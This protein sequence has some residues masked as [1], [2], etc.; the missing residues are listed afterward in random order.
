MKVRPA[1]ELPR[2]KQ[3]LRRRAIKLEWITLVIVVINIIV[4][5]FVL[6]NSQAMRTA[7]IEDILA[8]VPPL[9]FLTATHFETKSP[10]EKKP[11]GYFRAIDIAYLCASLALLVFGGYLLFESARTLI[12]GSHPSIGTIVIFGEQLWLGWLMIAGLVF[13]AIPPV[14]VGLL[15]LPVARQLH[16]K[17][18]YADA[19]MN[20]ADWLTSIAGIVG[21]GGIGLGFW[22]LDAAA[23]MIIAA[24]IAWDGIRN[25]KRVVEDLLDALPRQVESNREEDL[26]GKI[27]QT[28]Q[29][30]DWIADVN[31]RMREEGH[32]FSGE[33]TVMPQGVTEV[34]DLLR[35][36]EKAQRKILALDWRLYDFSI[37][38]VRRDNSAESA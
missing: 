28:L 13:T 20:K 16:D 4:L 3:E 33:A 14:I 21:V 38:P 17:V 2:E 9:A 10:N 11:Y 22:W 25:L 19:N 27:R 26:P 37:V 24:D 35:R 36:L 8:L 32:V 30:M 23:A 7:W 31:V 6:G 15:K 1:F 34:E 12:K 18:L 5:Y 29:E